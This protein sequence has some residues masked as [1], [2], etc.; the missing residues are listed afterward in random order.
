[1]VDRVSSS[2]RLVSA[3]LLLALAFATVAAKAPTVS[4]PAE[5]ASLVEGFYESHLRGDMGFSV[6]SVKAKER[7]FTPALY[8]LLRDE[9]RKPPSPD[10]VP[11][12]DGDPFTDSQEYPD[13]FEVGKTTMIGLKAQVPV[14]FH[15]KEKGSKSWKLQVVLTQ[16]GG[17]W[18]IDDFLYDRAKGETPKTLRALLAQK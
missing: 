10:E 3:A 14:T 17:G 8:S 9:L 6:E 12:V 13:K 16:N 7:W 11:N 1:M 15:F 5:A 2:C 4:P 18:Q